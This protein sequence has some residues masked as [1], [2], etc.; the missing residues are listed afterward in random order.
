MKW[1]ESTGVHG[2]AC[3]GRG[4]LYLLLAHDVLD[5]GGRPLPRSSVQKLHLQPE[6]PLW[7]VQNPFWALAA[8]TE[9]PNP[10]QLQCFVCYF[11]HSVVC[12]SV[13]RFMCGQD[14]L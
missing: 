10:R 14:A 13:L 6:T 12:V 7:T 8:G 4:L 1:Q 11:Q 2:L 9:S 3:M 5:F